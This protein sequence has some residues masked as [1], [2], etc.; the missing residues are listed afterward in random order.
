[1][2]YNQYGKSAIKAIEH[3]KRIPTLSPSEAWDKATS[4]LFGE[5]T[6]AQ[7]KQCPKNT[8]LAIC[9]TGRIKGVKP[10]DYTKSKKNKSYAIEG[11]KLL[12]QNKTL[13]S[14]KMTL[15]KAIPECTNLT[16]NSQMD[17]LIALYSSENF[18]KP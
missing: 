12:E 4:E 1:M 11:L 6:P 13:M 5:N 10:G 7:K 14:N 17:V 9:E 3:L 2:T 8:F 18:M 16:Y 15:W